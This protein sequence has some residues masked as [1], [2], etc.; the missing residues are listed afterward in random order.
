MGTALN[1]ARLLN[2]PKKWNAAALPSIACRQCRA[3]GFAG[4]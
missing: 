3:V 1:L 4:V 2:S